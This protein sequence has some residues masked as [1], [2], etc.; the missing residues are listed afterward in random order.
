[1]HFHCGQWQAWESDARFICVI[2]GTQSGKTSF[3]PLWLYREIQ[4]RGAGDYL[5]ITPTFALLEKKALP[6]FRKHFERRLKLGV[7]VGSPVR[8]FTFNQ[9]GSLR[10][11]G[12]YDPDN[13]TTV[14]FGYAED[15]ESLESA[16]AKAAWL[17]E[18][19]QK[20]FKLDSWEAVLR[21]LS[22]AMG[23][24]LVTTTPYDLGWL[25]Q[26]I[27][28][29]WRR[30]GT[31]TEQPGDSDFEVVRFDS[32]ENPQFPPEEFERA[33]QSLPDW[34]FNLFYRGIFTRPA[35]LIY[36]SFEEAKHKIKRF[37]IPD[38]WPRVL[39]LDFGGVNTA[40]VFYA[41]NPATRP[42]ATR[43]TLGTGTWYAYREYKAGSRAAA[44]HCYYLMLKEKA[45]PFCAGG[46]H[47]EDQWRH[48]FRKGGEIEIGGQKL[49]V[50]GLDVRESPI[51]DVEVGIDRVYG[52]HKRD[53]IYV[54]E[55]LRQ[56]LEQKLTYSRELDEFGEPTEKIA[57]K[58]TFHFMDAE[59]Y[60]V[61]RL[62]NAPIREGTKVVRK[63]G[64]V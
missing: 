6:E 23:R 10:T 29:R 37:P 38:D 30:I 7:Y 49:K 27:Y 56:Y 52:A 35:G 11:F 20:K 17:D 26:Q 47:S 16:T 1:M 3:G 58:E 50:A 22:L 51:K 13:P 39:G 18:A 14:F 48:E 2:A 43:Q 24:V 57:D 41:E 53:E 64:Y 12:S 32:T 15:P 28:D 45:T 5:V 60:I 46:S 19:G 31:G 21:R 40:G 33:R 36:D 54:F 63:G 59:R 44:E 9:E 8:K 4:R 34:K 25:K 61:S 55:D 62:K 42:E